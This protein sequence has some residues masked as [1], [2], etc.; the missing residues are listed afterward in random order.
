MTEIN[1]DFD[2]YKIFGP[3]E[4]EEMM[5]RAEMTTPTQIRH[6]IPPE[7]QIRAETQ[8]SRT[9]RAGQLITNTLRK[10]KKYE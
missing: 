2:P 1:K 9:K 6:S 5:R 3:G 4:L 10:V 8:Q 7:T